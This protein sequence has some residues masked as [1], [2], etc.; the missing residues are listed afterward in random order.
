MRIAVVGDVHAQFDE[1]DVEALEGCGYDLIL[2]VGDIADWMHRTTL[3]TARRMA[4]LRTPALCLPGNHD[5]TTPWGVLAEALGIGTHRPG[6]GRRAARRLTE[7]RRAL[8][9]IPLVGYSAHPFPAHDLTVIA[10]R[11]LA[12]DGRR[13][14]FRQ[15][16]QHTWD[17]DSMESSVR[18]LTTLVDSNPGRL[19]LLAH[20]GPAGLG[21]GKQAPFSVGGRDIGDPDLAAVIDHAMQQQRRV[22]AVVAGHVHHRSSDRQWHHSRDGV[23][24]VNAARVPRVV[25]SSAHGQRHH[26][27]RLE[28]HDDH[29]VDVEEIWA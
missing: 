5:G 19:L 6:A 4:Q 26:H 14:C 8:H 7:L 27:V 21:S 28:I 29:T 16:L 3:V 15:A 2:F 12:M 9:P 18:T 11:P 10:G 20:N 1:A 23:H 13:L 22:V 17:V 25:T 24:Y